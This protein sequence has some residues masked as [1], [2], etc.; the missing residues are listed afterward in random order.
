MALPETPSHPLMDS[1]DYALYLTRSPG[2][3]RRGRV[4][5]VLPTPVMTPLPLDVGD[6]EAIFGWGM[7]C[8]IQE[9]AAMDVTCQRNQHFG[10]FLQDLRTGLDFYAS[11]SAQ[12]YIGCHRLAHHPICLC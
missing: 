3:A 11:S 9:A 2:Q 10:P 7:R 4:V 6:D 12:G 8:H 5:V 1:G